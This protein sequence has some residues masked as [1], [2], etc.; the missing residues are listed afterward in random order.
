MTEAVDRIG[1]EFGGIDIAVANAG[2][3]PTR[4]RLAAHD[5]LRRVRAG[6]RGRPDGRLAHRAR[7][8]LPQII[9][10]RGHL[11]VVSS[12]YAFVNGTLQLALRDRQG[13]G[14]VDGPGD[15]LGAGR[16]RRLRRGRLLRL[17]RH[18]HGPRRL[19]RARRRR[20][21]RR[22]CPTSS[23]S[24][25]S[26]RRPPPSSS[27]AS[28]AGRRGRSPRAGGAPTRPCAASSTRSSTAAWRRTTTSSRRSARP[29]GS[30][31]SARP[32]SE[33]VAS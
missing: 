5:G 15:P 31:P 19:R 12:V 25:C 17:H 11:V 24:D 27:A 9:A 14:R 4:A 32:S 3:A 29:S 10:R 2:I 6:D 28:S 26:P 8:T 21:S 1:E 30:T 16:D 18:R 23:A 13:R 7:A 33:K 20:S 22:R